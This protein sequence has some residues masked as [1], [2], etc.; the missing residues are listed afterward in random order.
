MNYLWGP[1]GTFLPRL[2]QIQKLGQ[3]ARDFFDQLLEIILSDCDSSAARQRQRF[4]LA[5]HS[6]KPHVKV[7]EV[8]F[9]VDCNGR[10]GFLLG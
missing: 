4:R 9:E 1:E 10:K 5:H 7:A 3:A 6:S 2:W 8:V